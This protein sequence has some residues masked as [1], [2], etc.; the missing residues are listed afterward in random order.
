MFRIKDRIALGVMAGLCGNLV[1]T[2]IDEV[3]L[4]KKISQRS[5]RETASGV[6]VSNLREASNVKGQILGVL[7][8]YGMG[9]LGGIGTV[10]LLSKTGK[11]QLFIKGIISGVTL[12]SG[13][14][15]ILSASPQNKVKP[16]DAASNLS[17]L[18]SHAAFGLVTSFVASKLGDTTLFETNSK[19]KLP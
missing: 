1:K 19:N 15:A 6:W 9:A 13:I 10:C 3:S 11:D 4:R 2:A 14:T 16:K 8:D 5:F 12:G 17:Y 7:L 18:I